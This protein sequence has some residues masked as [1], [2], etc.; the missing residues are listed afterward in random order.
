MVAVV[1]LEGEP[2]VSPGGLLRLL[3]KLP[4]ELGVGHQGAEAIEHGLHLPVGA[5][6]DLGWD[7]A[8]DH[9][10]EQVALVVDGH[11]APTVDLGLDLGDPGLDGLLL[12]ELVA[13]LPGVLRVRRQLGV[14][15]LAV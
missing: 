6:G 7:G 1:D 9:L 12:V 8:L 10:P 5:L 4:G 14:R 11:Q 15:G 13:D 2:H 3:C